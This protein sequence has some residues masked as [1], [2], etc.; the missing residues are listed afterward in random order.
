LHYTAHFYWNTVVQT[1]K[2]PQKA[3]EK[4]K[5]R[6]LLLFLG[7]ELCWSF[8]VPLLHLAADVVETNV[9]GSLSRSE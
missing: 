1:K 2:T 3:K 9:A 4:E 6:H 5:N 8:R 7:I